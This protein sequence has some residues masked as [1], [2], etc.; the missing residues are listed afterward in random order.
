VLLRRVAGFLQGVSAAKGWRSWFAFD[1]D[2]DN[3]VR[4]IDEF[5][6]QAVLSGSERSFL[7]ASSLTSS[8]SSSR[9][10]AIKRRSLR[11][12]GADTNPRCPPTS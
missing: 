6:K 8:T 4:V 2:V 11:S 10:A 12:H 3:V 5:L 9:R 1:Y 7:M